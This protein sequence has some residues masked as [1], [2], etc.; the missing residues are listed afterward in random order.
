MKFPRVIVLAL[1]ALGLVAC[2]ASPVAEAERR[3]QAAGIGDY[4]IQV[5]E[6]HSIWCLYD[7]EVNVRGGQVV[8]A[9]VTAQ[10][11]PAQDCHLYVHGVVGEPV[12]IPPEEARQWTVEGLFA[13]ARILD[14]QRGDKGMVV[15]LEFDPELGYPLTLASDNVQATDDDR[16]IAIRHFEVLAPID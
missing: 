8:S 14:E 3:W 1:L 11:G 5:R 16:M 13:T 12:P 15:T 4:R 2:G 9:T 10:P 6:V 7:A